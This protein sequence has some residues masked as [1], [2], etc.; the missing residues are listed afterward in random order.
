[1]GKKCVLGGTGVGGIGGKVL[2]RDQLG[3][4]EYAAAAV[5]PMVGHSRGAA[6]SAG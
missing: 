6:R 2:V 4:I 3:V 1:M 5:V